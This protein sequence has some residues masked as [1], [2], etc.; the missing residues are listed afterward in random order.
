[1][2]STPRRPFLLALLVLTLALPILGAP[3]RAE[4]GE[5]TPLRTERWYEILLRGQKLG[6]QKVV[7]APSTWEGKK[8]V[9]DTTVVTETSVRDML[10]TKDVFEV[11]TT[12]DLERG[13]D[14]TL[15]W[16]KTAV[17]EADR[18]VVTEWTWTGKGYLW[19]SRFKTEERI[20]VPADAP[21]PADAEAFLGARV[22]AGAVH[23]GD[24]FAL[25][26]LDVTARKVATDRLEVVGREDVLDPS[27]GEAARVGA[28][29]VK[30]TDPESGEVSRIWIDDEGAFVRIVS[31][32]G[33]VW[34]RVARDAAERRAVQPAES[35]ITTPS[36]PQLERV[37]SAD[38][39]WLDVHV[40][41]DPDRARPELPDSPWSRVA[42]LEG[43][44]EAG[45][46]YHLVL[47]RYD[48]P[49]ADTTLP[50]APEGFERDLEATVLMQTEDPRVVKLARSIVGTEK[51]ARRASYL[52]ARYVFEHLEKESTAVGQA[53]ALEI[54]DC[55]QGDCSEHALLFVTLCRAVG[56]PARICSGYVCVGSDWGAHS[57]AEIW[58][59][60]WISSDPTTGE[61]GGAARY[62]FFGYPDRPDSHPG[63]VSA[64]AT[65]RMRI[66]A[67]RIQEGEQTFDLTDP[68]GWQVH[69]LEHHRFVNVLAGIEVRDAPDDW[70][71]RMV[72]PDGCYLRA[73]G[74]R[75]E[76]RA[77]ADQ[78][79]TLARLGGA[80]GTFAGAP[81]RILR[82]GDQPV[83]VL[84]QSR[85]R[86]LTFLIEADDIDG[87]IAALE[88]AFAP[89]FAAR[90]TAFVPPEKREPE[91]V[92]KDRA[93]KEAPDGV[94]P[95]KDDKDAK[96]AKD[97]KDDAPPPARGER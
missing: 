97:A 24:R 17:E 61:I 85:R 94:R 75:V 2:T 68:A 43:S 1:M 90:P 69:D 44:D 60:R 63:L 16:M 28:F 73:P 49:S 65:G 50:I 79:Y 80:S 18:T 34:Q 54:L 22:R 72:S 3:A 77:S 91:P 14:G 36:K 27:R 46:V 58:V 39:L 10:G 23:V 21:V 96:D 59:G 89:T 19:V 29:V 55:G 57:W 64:R 51:S 31:D 93:P 53:S 95:G 42:G 56:I 83:R 48:D 87:S 45:W 41:S 7:W 84:V 12:I 13:D 47:S 62:V 9:H 20:E 38:R 26:V 74:L 15:W 37:M 32:R 76:V 4:S 33:Q 35:P 6:H 25:P 82:Y 5:E 70:V 71:V 86:I 92:A 88:R 67:T 11:V 8:T 40:Q 52:L 30:Q 66:V 81:A 78:G